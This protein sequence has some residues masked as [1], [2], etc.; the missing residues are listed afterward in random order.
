M[1]CL[2]VLFIALTGLTAPVTGTTPLYLAGLFPMGG[3]GRGAE[4][5]PGVLPAV[6]I[7]RRH[8][9]KA[10]DILK[11]YNLEIRYNDTEVCISYSIIICMLG[12]ARF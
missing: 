9:N 12:F 3:K 7:A 5:G 11:G 6:E 4:I 10:K 8:V 1:E 2:I